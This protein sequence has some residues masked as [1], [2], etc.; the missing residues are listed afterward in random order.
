MSARSQLSN[1][2]RLG[3]FGQKPR[4][5]ALHATALFACRSVHVRLWR[6]KGERRL[7]T[8]SL[9]ADEVESV[10]NGVD[11]STDLGIRDRAILETFYSAGI[12]YGELI[13]LDV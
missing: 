10:L 7:P 6:P 13:N 3:P 8:G 11:V 9:T 4:G 1:A 5:H 2:L 12:R